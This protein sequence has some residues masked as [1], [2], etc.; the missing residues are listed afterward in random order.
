MSNYISQYETLGKDYILQQGF[1][2]TPDQYCQALKAKVLLIDEGHQDFHFNFKLFLYTHCLVSVTS[3]ATLV[4]DDAFLKRMAAMAYPYD[5]RFNPGTKNNYVDCIGVTYRFQAPKYLRYTGRQGYSHTELEKSIMRHVPT[6]KSYY[7]MIATLIENHYIPNRKPGYKAIVFCS[8]INM[9]EK[10]TQYLKERDK[11]KDLDIRKYIGESDYSDLLEPD[12]RV[13]TPGSAGTAVDI[14]GLY[15]G[16]NTVAIGST[17]MNKQI[18]G[19]LR[20]MKKGNPIHPDGDNPKFIWLTC[21][22]I[23]QHQRY[24]KDKQHVFNDKMRSYIENPY[25]TPIGS[26]KRNNTWFC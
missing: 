21:M 18:I 1:I 3:T 26:V 6:E 16:I 11:L 7:E 5:T 20:E 10:L 17:P 24:H 14:P 19:R 15:L 9:C 22:D 4:P 2:Y 12:I 23:P 8:T 25:Y 13:T